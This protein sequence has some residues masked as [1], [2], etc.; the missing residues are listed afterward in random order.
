[1]LEAEPAVTNSD[2]TSVT[3]PDAAE[4]PKETAAR[5]AGARKL[6]FTAVRVIA[7]VAIAFLLVRTTIQQ[8][9]KVSATIASLS[10]GWVLVS[11]LAALAGIVGN[12]LAWRAIV[13]DLGHPLTVYD[14][15]PITF[16]GQLGKYIPGSVWAYVAQMELGRR[17]GVP[18]S[19]GFLASIITVGI[20]II[21]GF[22]VGAAGLL[23]VGR[24]SDFTQLRNEAV[25]PVFLYGAIALLPVGLVCLHPKVM[26]FF[27]SLAPR[28]IRRPPLE[29]PLSWRAMLAAVLWTVG[30]YLCFGLHLWALLGDTGGAGIT[31][32]VRSIGAMALGLSLSTVVI[33]APS[34]IGVR[35]LIIS[36]TLGGAAGVGAPYAIA[37]VSRLVFTA[38]D[39]IAAAIGV[40]IYLRYRQKAARPSEG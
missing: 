9:D 30:A 6:L 3:A 4:T 19:R 29:R 16:L 1:M 24:A 25:G 8:W 33:V 27:V 34:G 5:S 21:V 35:E 11:T 10:W 17:V 22:L 26:T 2:G 38:A 13:A 12:V 18:R 40:A 7:V 37:L 23:A 28:L 15:L 14:A 32:V 36:L 20:G 31:G 39:V